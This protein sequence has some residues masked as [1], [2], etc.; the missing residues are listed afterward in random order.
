MCCSKGDPG[1]G[2]DGEMGGG[3]EASKMH[4]GVISH[5]CVGL[6]SIANP[7]DEGVGYKQG[8]FLGSEIVAVNGDSKKFRDKDP[9]EV[10]AEMMKNEKNT[11]HVVGPPSRN[12]KCS[13]PQHYC[14]A[15]GDRQPFGDPEVTCR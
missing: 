14:N 13:E 8:L 10:L 6:P 15:E 9:Q 1:I 11:L 4:K 12:P 5:T 2:C 7:A 3:T